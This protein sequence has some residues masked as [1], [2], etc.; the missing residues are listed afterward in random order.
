MRPFII[1]ES[2]RRCFQLE[3]P[4]VFGIISEKTRI[5]MVIIAETSPNHSL[6]KTM[7]A[8][9]PTPAAPRVL[10]IVLRESIAAIGRSMSSFIFSINFAFLSPSSTLAEM[11]EIGVD[12]STD[13]RRE[14]RNDIAI[15]PK[16]NMRSRV[17]GLQSYTFPGQTTNRPNTF[18]RIGLLRFIVR[19]IYASFLS[20]LSLRSW[21]LSAALS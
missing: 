14:Q 20:F 5:R 17:I 6:P 12:I 15:A 9:L 13:S 2:Q 19:G 11:K 10:A 3:V 16:R 18:S 8:C 21:T 7:V 4:M 1:L